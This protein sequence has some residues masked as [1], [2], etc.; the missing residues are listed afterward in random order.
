M[1]VTMV[2]LFKLTL[3]FGT[4]GS[5]LCKTFYVTTS[6]NIPCPPA[7]HCVTLSQI[8]ANSSGYLKPG[9]A[10][11]L[12]IQQ[13][14]HQLDSELLIT[15]VE[16]LLIVSNNATLVHTLDY[17]TDLCV[18]SARFYDIGCVQISGLNFIQ[19]GGITVESVN[20]FM[21]EDSMF[22]NSS[23]TALQLINT[24]ANIV[25]SSFMLNSVGNYKNPIKTSRGETHTLVGSA[26]ITSQSNV[27]ILNSSFEEN[28]AEIGGAIFGELYSQIT[29]YK[30]NFSGNRANT[31][32][33]L[34]TD[35]GCTVTVYKGTFQNNTSTATYNGF[36]GVIGSSD[37]V[38]FIDQSYFTHNMANNSGGVFNIASKSTLNINGSEF[39]YNRAEGE[40]N[41]GVVNIEGSSVVINKSNFKHTYHGGVIRGQNSVIV[42]H[43][44][45]FDN[46]TGGVIRATQGNI[47]VR[48]SE[49]TRNS[50]EISWYGGVMWLSD[51]NISITECTFTDNT[52]YKGGVL[53]VSQTNLN[54]ISS[55]FYRNSA[56]W[57]GVVRA[58]AGSFVTTENH[59]VIENNTGYQGV[60]HFMQSTGIFSGMTEFINNKGS[61]IVHYSNVTFTTNTSFIGG[62][63]LKTDKIIMYQEGGAITGFQSD[64]ALD[65]TCN[66]TNN[67]AENGGA[68]YTTQSKVHVLGQVIITNNTAT[69]N[70]GGIY[71][72]QSELN[73]QG[74]SSLMLVGNNATIKGGGVHSISSLNKVNFNSSH[75]SYTGSA[76]QFIKNSAR[77]GGGI[78]L[79]MSSKFYIIRDDT[80]FLSWSNEPQYIVI[81]LG[82]V[83]DYGGA[84]YVADDTNPATCASISYKTHS[85]TTECFLQTLALRGKS[86]IKIL[87]IKFTQNKAK[88]SGQCLFGGLLDRCTVS[89]FSETY[90]EHI[91]HEDYKNLA[92]LPHGV[93]YLS[94]VSNIRDY[95]WISSEPVQLYFCRDGQP[96]YSN[97]QSPINIKPGET[98]SVSLIAVDQIN[99]TVNAT[100]RSSLY[101]FESGLGE[102][103]LV[104]STTENC[105]NLSFTIFSPHKFEELIIY[106]EGPCKDA[107]MSQRRL[108]I[109]LSPCS[110]PTGF[111]VKH[112]KRTTCECECD[113]DLPAQITECNPQSGTLIRERNF[114]ITYVNNTENSGYVMHSNCPF[115]YCY[116][117]SSRV[118][119][120]LAI[121]GGADAQCEYNRS[122]KL[123]GACQRGL[124]L[125]LSSPR[126]LPCSKQWPVVFTVI[127]LIAFLLGIALVASLMVLNLTVAV[128]TL[129]GLIFYANIV[130]A[131]S[132]IYFPFGEPKFI[133]TY[134][135]WINLDLG[136]DV[137]FFEGIDAYWKTWLQLA[138]PTY[139]VFLVVVVIAIS[140]WSAKFSQFVGKWNPVATLA[141][142]ILLS[143]TK[144]LHTIIAALSSAVLDYPD[145][146]HETVWLPDATVQY[147]LGKHSAL[148]IAAILILVICAAYTI[149]LLSW[150]W[151]VHLQNKKPFNILINQKLSLFIEPYHA[152]YIPN[153][154]YWTGLLLFVRIILYFTSAL[155]VSGDPSINLFV[156]GVVISFLLFLKGHFGNIYRNWLLGS[157]EIASYLNIVLFSFV[158][159]FTQINGRHQIAVAYISGITTLVLILGVL[160]YHIFTELISKTKLWSR[161]KSDLT[162]RQWSTNEGTSLEPMSTQSLLTSTI[163][164]APPRREM[165]LYSELREKLLEPTDGENTY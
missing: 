123:C 66:L 38:V 159:F 141:T 17:T 2:L 60:V 131:N 85:T 107:N 110:C 76:V 52:A 9:T 80:R 135:A 23:E 114:W 98:F 54:L 42:I 35:S 134:I 157:L 19:S 1:S 40:Y 10:V 16:E 137:C 62:S 104:Q 153:H 103:Q 91:C 100:I 29:V 138:F 74:H 45:N 88:I 126:C 59:I 75:V 43:N 121:Q 69:E 56:F 111:Q 117:A 112:T 144:F 20:Q 163:V 24:T 18:K 11:T 22:M 5:I 48:N 51:T 64:I 95:Q 13:G 122:G 158:T 6:V 28:S 106:A 148:F 3:L 55:K 58:L 139:I 109:N 125:S 39:S 119:I 140:K 132:N 26:V 113:S 147:F 151:L 21:L 83:A 120:N 160:A 70:G 127:L 92:D 49:F 73:C 124:S 118:E 99:H 79:E 84:V 149:L 128:G 94:M 164:D 96:D 32:G 65:G 142:L 72:Y 34:Y 57:G 161:V 102:G 133:T 61:F 63:Q 27:T 15:D 129:N 82:N 87:N 53:E 68:I 105:T 136:V 33:A 30:S 146:S 71:L 44:S 108:Q 156:V 77:Q 67:S 25:R 165:S 115:D 8:A 36:G 12:V 145:G 7:Q 154:R 14:H 4:F 81:F 152:P 101:S 155:N 150:Q 116:P 78:C 86:L 143:Y 41:G 89:P 47:D 50:A 130:N 97:Q 31:G 162:Q 90:E 46:N 93:A 37:G